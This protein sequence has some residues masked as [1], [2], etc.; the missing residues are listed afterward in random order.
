MEETLSTEDEA[1]K[2]RDTLHEIEQETRWLLLSRLAARQGFCFVPMELTD[3]LD[4]ELHIDPGAIPNEEQIIAFHRRL[5]ADLVVA[6]SIL[7]YGK[8]RWQWA[9]GGLIAHVT[10]ERII[11]VFA[12]AW[13][14][15]V[16]GT[17]FG[18]DLLTEIPIW[19]GGTYLF[20]VALRP[21]RVE[22]RAFET[23]HGY[24]I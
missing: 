24:P 4:E 11:V 12:S 3:A 7:D 14:P 9:L 18:F 6:G 17:N 21:V 20:G 5:G 13:N 23:I 8:V 2:L 22:A 10:I 19:F 1:Q 16:I 15:I